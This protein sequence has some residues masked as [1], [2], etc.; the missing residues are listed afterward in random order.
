[1]IVIQTKIV[2]VVEIVLGLGHH[3]INHGSQIFTAAT[4][5]DEPCGNF[6]PTTAD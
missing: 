2:G 1:M 3:L 4:L 6:A 5:D